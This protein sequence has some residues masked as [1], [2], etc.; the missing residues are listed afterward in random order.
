MDKH[1]KLKS[2]HQQ[3]AIVTL[4]NQD[5]TDGNVPVVTRDNHLHNPSRVYYNPECCHFVN[6]MGTSA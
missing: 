1:G 3:A 4:H 6:Y 5:K 2:S